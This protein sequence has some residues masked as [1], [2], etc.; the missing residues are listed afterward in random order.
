MIRFAILFFV[1]LVVFIALIVGPL[2]A[3]KYLTGFTLP[4][5]LAQPTGLNSNDT[6]STETGTAADGGAAATDTAAAATSLAARMLRI[7]NY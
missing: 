7:R 4:L 2:V 6:I 3:G 1:M 5:E